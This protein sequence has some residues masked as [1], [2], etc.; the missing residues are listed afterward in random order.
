MNFIAPDYAAVANVNPASITNGVTPTAASGTTAATLRT[1]VDTLF[2]SWDTNYLSSQGAVW[3]ISPQLARAISNM[4]SSLSVPIFPTMTP[5]GGTFMG[6]SGH[7][8]GRGHSSGCS[9]GVR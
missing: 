6:L 4:V 9:P 2:S 1:D 5:D 8:L 3:V 7:R